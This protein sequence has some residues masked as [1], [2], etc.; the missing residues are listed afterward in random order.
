M[1]QRIG[2]DHVAL[3][4]ER[5]KDAEVRHIACIEDHRIFCMLEGCERL[6][7]LGQ[8]ENSTRSQPRTARAGAIDH[9]APRGS[10]D[11]AFMS[12]AQVV[13]GVEYD[14]FLP[15]PPYSAGCRHHSQVF[16]PPET[17]FVR[18]GGQC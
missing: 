11:F 10:H 13:I 12:H 16:D 17:A 18:N 7:Q 2:K 1:I 6:L 9:R 14:V 5:I 8:L 3:A 15:V 4:G